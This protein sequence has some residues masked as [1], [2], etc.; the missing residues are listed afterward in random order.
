MLPKRLTWFDDVML[1]IVITSR[2][3]SRFIRC[4][5]RTVNRVRGLRTR[6][7]RVFVKDTI[8]VSQLHHHH[9]R[10]QLQLQDQQS[11]RYPHL[12]QLLMTGLIELRSLRNDEVKTLLND[13]CYCCCGTFA[14]SLSNRRRH[15]LLSN[16]RKK[17]CL[18][19]M[20]ERDNDSGK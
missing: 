8:C 14:V 3:I 5:R 12:H 19:L 18:C 10:Y 2:C 16:V 9:Y 1:V 4:N 7:R 15:S 11:C 6:R 20:W 13:F 17:S